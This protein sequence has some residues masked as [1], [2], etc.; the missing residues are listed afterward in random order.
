MKTLMIGKNRLLY[1][2]AAALLISLLLSG[3]FLL[4][5][6]KNPLQVFG[7][8]FSGAFGSAFGWNETLIVACPIML[9]ALSVSVAQ[10]IGLLSIGAEG[11]LY[12]GALGATLMLQLLGFNDYS[13]WLLLPL[14]L[15]AAV[16]SGA[17]LSGIPGYLKGWIGVNETLTTLLLNFIAVLLVQYFINNG[18]KDASTFNWPQ[19]RAL[20]LHAEIPHF[21]NSRLHF[22]V[23]AAPV[24]A[25]LLWF[26]YDH[27]KWGLMSKVIGQ[28]ADLASSYH[29]RRSK[30]ILMLMLA[31]GAIAGLAGFIQLSAIEGRLR[32]P[33]SLD[34]GYTGF[35]VSWLAD[36]RPLLIIPVA[37]L[38]AGLITGSDNVQ[39]MN[40]LPFA[41][42]KILQGTLFITFLIVRF[43]KANN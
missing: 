43:S 2:I 31:S 30:Y 23:F 9:C 32:F 37:I 26:F 6:A 14:T 7:G 15:L 28:N 5:V 11:Q 39:I 4:T 34:Y 24:I 29:L 13:T 10:R 38:L 21:G 41:F 1:Q 20:P 12:F 33:I 25:V 40:N 27:T 36:H 42:T 8:I 3:V 35:L 17:F 19:S 18:L 22:G 16:L